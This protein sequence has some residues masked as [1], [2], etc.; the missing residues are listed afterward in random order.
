MWYINTWGVFFL[1]FNLCYLNT[2]KTSP[3]L[4]EQVMDYYTDPSSQL[5][6]MR[7]LLEAHDFLRHIKVK[8]AEL[9]MKLQA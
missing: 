7:L 8:Y 3:S 2:T 1:P 4:E 6:L 5:I 9:R